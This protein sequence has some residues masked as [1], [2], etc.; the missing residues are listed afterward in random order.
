MS[1][2]ALFGGQP[3]FEEP[4]DPR[5]FWPPVDA[6]TAENLQALYLSRCWTAFDET[7]GIFA[8]AF[9]DHHGARHGVFMMNGTVTLQ[10][11]LGACGIGAGDE[12]IVP[13]LTWYATAIAVHYVGARPV[14]VDV[15]RETLCIDPEKITP[16]ITQRTKAIIPVHLYGSTADMDR[17]CAIAKRHNLRVIED[18]AHVHGGVWNGRRVGSIG[19]IGSFSFQ[20]AKTMASGEGGICITSDDE[21]AERIFRMKHIGY[22]RG[23][24]PGNVFKGPPAGL[25]C[26]QFRATAFQAL[27]LMEQL[28]ALD[29][30]LDRYRAAADYLEQRLAQQTR[31]RFQK[32]G[33]KA[34]RQG[35]FGWV[36]MFDDPGYAHI[37]LAAIQKALVA[38]GVP[39]MAT[40]EPVYR[41][42]L[43]NLAADTYRIDQPCSVSEQVSG[44][45]L[46]LLH[47]VLGLDTDVIERV[48]DA[49]AKVMANAD[50]LRSYAA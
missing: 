12:V 40:W 5:K 36:M 24:R 19:D 41:F 28:R 7:E 23:E 39:A 2:L 50:E 8:Q 10:C 49:I 27:V 11:A 21:I 1:K 29:N 17:I 4:I 16:A 26:H 18:C 9:A 22:G 48:G 33:S 14:F 6:V 3:V 13:A 43:F 32:R 30:R 42:V 47:A 37:P 38:E 31:L 25:L 20:Q 35:Y 15:D 46:W 45:V 34:D 44:R